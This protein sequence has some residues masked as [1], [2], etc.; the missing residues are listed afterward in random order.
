L[1][2][3]SSKEEL[4]DNRVED[5]VTAREIIGQVRSA[6]NDNSAEVISW[7]GE[8]LLERAACSIEFLKV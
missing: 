4:E 5:L 8:F 1:F 3:Q 6:V 7:G 2:S